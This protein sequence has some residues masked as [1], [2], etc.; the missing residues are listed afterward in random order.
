MGFYI[1]P[2]P[3]LARHLVSYLVMNFT[4]VRVRNGYGHY[5]LSERA[6]ERHGLLVWPISSSR[7]YVE[8]SGADAE[9]NLIPLFRLEIF[10][11]ILFRHV[12]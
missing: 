8:L 11:Y 1:S 2:I 12:V 7:F 3:S 6:E 10:Y 4:F 5:A 9:G